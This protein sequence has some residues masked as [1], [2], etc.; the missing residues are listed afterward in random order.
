MLRA[1]SMK[2]L[3]EQGYDTVRNLKVQFLIIF[4]QGLYLGPIQ[5]DCE[6][7]IR[8]IAAYQ[9]TF[10]EGRVHGYIY[11]SSREM[12]HLD[13][14]LDTVAR[15]IYLFRHTDKLG[16]LTDQRKCDEPAV[17]KALKTLEP[18]P[19]IYKV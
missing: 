10:H 2:S 6:E 16:V 3:V 18:Y 9:A 5:D 17:R 4:L 15:Y 19:Q 8:L 1:K 13:F 7:R 11:K 12:T 14:K